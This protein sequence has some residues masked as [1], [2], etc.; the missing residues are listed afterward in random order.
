M[1]APKMPIPRGSGFIRQ[2]DP[3]QA[4]SDAQT[5]FRSLIP[6]KG[7]PRIA[8]IENHTALSWCDS[9]RAVPEPAWLISRLE[10]QNLEK[11]YKGFSSDGNPDS[12]VWNWEKDSEGGAPVNEV[13]GAM[14]VLLEKLGE[15]GRKQVHC[16]E[17]DGD[18][19]R[20]WSNPELYM[21]PGGIRLDET[22]EEVQKGIH[23]V[24]RAS[25]SPAGYRKLWG[26]C[27]TNGFLGHLVDGRKVMNEHSYNFRIFGEIPPADKAERTGKEKWAYTFFGH[28]L[29]AAVVFVG[30]RE[31]I[32]PVF[33]GAE[34][35]EIDEGPDA[36]LR[37]FQEQ[38][39]GALRLMQGLPGEQRA[40]AHISKGMDGESLPEDRWNPFDERHLGG[41]RQDN[42]IV[43]FE[44]LKVSEMKP[45]HRE[46]IISLFE[47]FN[48]YYPAPVMAHRLRQ[49]KEHFDQTYFAWI[50]GFRDR[51]AY[52]YRIHSPVAFLE[53]DFHCGIFLTNTTPAHCHIH[54]VN[55]L[56]NKGDYARALL[57]LENSS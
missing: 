12:S 21:N 56:P 15:Q 34:P 54:T 48:L 33:M 2:N 42:R 6:P 55:R 31:V 28:H 18:E 26:C 38:E 41:A 23:D 3:S 49:F 24:I 14:N 44:G 37:L 5:P 39:M 11:P 27:L 16:G 32:G 45:E 35:D 47:F 10:A 25:M 7:H 8:G 52:Y 22:T 57:E 9:R 19:I 30:Q 43:P 29:C 13:A 51:D 53:F 20:L 17:V 50:G 40:K 4:P 46:V 1:A 36:G